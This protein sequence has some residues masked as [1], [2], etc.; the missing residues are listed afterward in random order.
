MSFGDQVLDWVLRHGK[1][2]GTPDESD[3]VLVYDHAALAS[4]SPSA[5]LGGQTWRIR[6]VTGELTL[7]DAL[8]EAGRLVAVVPHTFVVPMDLAGRAWLGRQARVRPR[9]L[10]AALT[11][12]PCEP[13]ADE[14]LARAIEAALPQLQALEGG[15][16]VGGTVSAREI[17]NVL[18]GLQVGT[19]HRFDREAPEALLARWLVEGSPEVTS[20]ELLTEALRQ[21][22]GKVRE[23]LGWAVTE[24]SVDA[25]V[26]AGAL[27]GTPE[28]AAAS[29]AV[30]TLFGPADRHRLRSVV[31]QAVRAA[32]EKNPTR[33]R[34][35]LEDAERRSTA[36][37]PT[38][39]PSHPLLSGLR[40][41][42]LVEAAKRAGAGT[43][44]ADVS[45]EALATNL[46]LSTHQPAYE[47]G[48]LAAAAML[49]LL[50]G[51]TPTV[52]VPL[53]RLIAR[54]SSRRLRG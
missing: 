31:E 12:R 54:E 49:Q 5:K 51:A 7:R 9:D 28:G 17:R 43:P 30:S 32:W 45:L 40:E 3:L 10:V 46:H 4:P 26:S 16:S 2:A 29:P 22:H 6:R 15:W 44:E 53:P 21:E 24:G 20:A 13:I 48:R 14:A 50:A 11:G 1:A 33:A 27:A 36:L 25:V 42:Y 18:L 41:R 19:Q 23:W 35:A 8:L 52:A 37:D 38:L 34:R 39:A 47:L